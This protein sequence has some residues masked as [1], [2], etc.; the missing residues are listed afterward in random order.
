MADISHDLDLAL[1]R[2]EEDP[3][4]PDP[5]FDAFYNS[6]DFEDANY[7]RMLKYEFPPLWSSVILVGF[8]LGGTSISVTKGVISEIDQR[9]A[10]SAQPVYLS[11][12]KSGKV[13]NMWV[14]AAMNPGNSGGPAFDM[15]GELLGIAWA[16]IP[17]AQNAGFLIPNIIVHNFLIACL[18]KPRDGG[19]VSVMLERGPIAKALPGPQV[20]SALEKKANAHPKQKH[21]K[22]PE[23]HSE[24]I[25]ES[26]VTTSEITT[27]KDGK[28]HEVSKTTVE[29]DK[30]GKRKKYTV[31]KKGDPK[32]PEKA[33]KFVSNEESSDKDNGKSSALSESI[34][35]NGNDISHEIQE[36][37]K[38]I[39]KKIFDEDPFNPDSFENFDSSFAEDSFPTTHD[40]LAHPVKA[41]HKA[42]QKLLAR[43]PADVYNSLVTR[44]PFLQDFDD[45]HNGKVREAFIKHF[46]DSKSN[47]SGED[48]LDKEVTSAMEKSA[49]DKDRK[50]SVKHYLV[51]KAME[52]LISSHPHIRN[53]YHDIER[54]NWED[55]NNIN[56]EQ[57]EHI[58]SPTSYVEEGVRA[59]AH[60]IFGNWFA[61]GQSADVT[62]PIH[63]PS[64]QETRAQESFDRSASYNPNTNYPAW[65]A[66]YNDQSGTPPQNEADYKQTTLDWKTEMDNRADTNDRGG[67]NPVPNNLVGGPSAVVLDVDQLGPEAAQ[68]IENQYLGKVVDKDSLGET[69]NP[70]VIPQNAPQYNEYGRAGIR[71]PG[72][73][74][75]NY[76]FQ[77]SDINPNIPLA[78]MV[79][80][81]PAPDPLRYGEARMGA[82]DP[83]S[84]LNAIM[85]KL[86]Y[87]L[88]HDFYDYDVNNPPT[89]HFIK[90]SDGVTKFNKKIMEPWTPPEQYSSGWDF[91]G[92]PFF[93]HPIVAKALA[94]SGT[95][96][97]MRKAPENFLVPPPGSFP[98]YFIP[99]NMPPPSQGHYDAN[100]DGRSQQLIMANGNYN[101]APNPQYPPQ[102]QKMEI[103]HQKGPTE[104]YVEAIGQ[105]GSKD[106]LSELPDEA[107][108][109]IPEHID[110][111]GVQGI[112]KENGVDVE[113]IGSQG[114]SSFVE[115]R[116]DG[117]KN[118][119]LMKKEPKA[120]DHSPD[121]KSDKVDNSKKPGSDMFGMMGQDMLLMLLLDQFRQS[122]KRK[123]EHMLRQLGNYH[124]DVI[125]DENGIPKDPS[126]S[127][128]SE[129]AVSTTSGF[130]NEDLVS[131]NNPLG[132]D[133]DSMDFK[134]QL[135]AATMQ[136]SLASTVPDDGFG[137]GSHTATVPGR[138]VQPS[139]LIHKGLRRKIEKDQ[140]SKK[141]VTGG[142]GA[143]S[144][145]AE[146]TKAFEYLKF[147]EANKGW[148]S[149]L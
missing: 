19:S 138:Y 99:P 114:S 145:Q 64:A 28:M 84:Y 33:Q 149:V 15:N 23:N 59:K 65:K 135:F 87:Y 148:V 74:Q 79:P 107:Q 124:A 90:A 86:E 112:Y 134:P 137:A 109:V 16:G 10:S 111:E 83:Q 25:S 47:H 1:M 27:G 82:Y 130:N 93:H 46:E 3:N 117:D 80:N 133:S 142:T 100:F 67:Y 9:D 18:G 116:E 129:E 70:A 81:V 38:A 30:D 17:G 105:D 94:L 54:A 119:N 58:I 61:H 24:V 44:F 131:I 4:N 101:V 127:S 143:V 118:S 31:V 29:E 12:V 97:D 125:G 140:K 126:S 147:N 51:R 8:P 132:A 36:R 71:I 88:G 98:S 14:D 115:M 113:N 92:N 5:D 53:G 56:A 49:D 11:K 20:T 95:Q 60:R 108:A 41:L 77:N 106:I 6:L 7:S 32:H 136:S 45:S 26:S 139:A 42:T 146:R 73:E 35:D 13:I 57:N 89:G 50:A 128:L 22:Q 76:L 75:N 144:V 141:D 62:D 39:E 63:L 21:H 52:K 122:K 68:H 34:S 121:N 102:P 66:F 72:P 37:E 110:H 78:K 2:V 103:T 43:K 48:K 69:Q 120:D 85:E 104:T 123:Q 96:S 55:I 40:L 91:S